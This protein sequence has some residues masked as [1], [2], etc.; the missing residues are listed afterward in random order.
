MRV[1][2]WLRRFT[3]S[4]PVIGTDTHGAIDSMFCGFGRINAKDP[5]RKLA[6]ISSSHQGLVVFARGDGSVD[7]LREA[8][9][10][11]NQIRANKSRKVQ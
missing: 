9:D 7:N 8:V 1:I 5:I 6:G 10:S 4:S 11:W 3:I 2:W